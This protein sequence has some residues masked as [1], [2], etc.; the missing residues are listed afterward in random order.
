MQPQRGSLGRPEVAGLSMLD[1]A[2]VLNRSGTYIWGLTKAQ[3]A[4][5]PL[6][7][8]WAV[9]SGSWLGEAS[10]S[11][12]AAG[13]CRQVTTLSSW[14]S[15]TAP[16]RTSEAQE[17]DCLLLGRLQG[18]AGIW[19]RLYR[20]VQVTRAAALLPCCE[21]PCS[22]GRGAKCCGSSIMISTEVLTSDSAKSM[23]EPQWPLTIPCMEPALKIT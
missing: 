16:T 20:H 1:A 15:Q 21:I 13:T 3:A 19:A 2:G 6:E 10:W 8:P 4:R 14:L 11:T 7:S 9:E 18:N 17:H 23:P 22:Y 12:S 5:A